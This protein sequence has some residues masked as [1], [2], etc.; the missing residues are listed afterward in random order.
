MLFGSPFFQI[1]QTWIRE[2]FFNRAE[3]AWIETY[4]VAC[5]LYGGAAAATQG[6]MCILESEAGRIERWSRDGELIVQMS[7]R[8]GRN[9]NVCHSWA[10]VCATPQVYPG[11]L[12][13]TS[14]TLDWNPA[15][16]IERMEAVA[17]L[18]S[19]KNVGGAESGVGDAGGGGGG[20]G[21]SSLG[22]VQIHSPIPLSSWREK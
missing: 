7:V 12:N 15:R 19:K 3:F 5:M 9:E 20:G 16:G 11:S 14:A 21:G 18:F 6:V 22:V 4:M 17:A 8:A 10:G 13:S 1:A 2:C